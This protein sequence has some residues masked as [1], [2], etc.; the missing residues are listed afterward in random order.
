MCAELAGRLR[1]ALVRECSMRGCS[2]QNSLVAHNLPTICVK[3]RQQLKGA[4]DQ[5][6]T[7]LWLSLDD[8]FQRKEI[9]RI[10]GPSKRGIATPTAP[11]AR[12]GKLARR[13][14]IV[15]AHGSSRAFS[16]LDPFVDIFPAKP[17]FS[18]DA[19]AR[20]VPAFE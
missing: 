7:A 17:V 2:M 4:R 5:A 19:K 1:P 3:G 20:Q 12:A 18:A 8:K 15:G 14:G 6:G 11:R 9:R 16:C 13:L 10:A